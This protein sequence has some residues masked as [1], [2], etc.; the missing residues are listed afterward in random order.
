MT[1]A[2][3]IAALTA[4]YLPIHPEHADFLSELSPEDRVGILTMWL[5]TFGGRRQILAAEADTLA[6]LL[7]DTAPEQAAAARALARKLR[8]WTIAGR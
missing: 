6:A 3:Y 4:R 1:D 2:T 7:D 5:D 8:E